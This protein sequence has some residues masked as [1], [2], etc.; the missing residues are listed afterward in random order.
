M[1]YQLETRR[2]ED[3]EIWLGEA[4]GERQELLIEARYTRQV[5][6]EHYGSE[7]RLA[8]QWTG[9]GCGRVPWGLT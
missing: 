1:H 7:G 5:L 2:L 4:S 8:I 6:G 3:D 9:E